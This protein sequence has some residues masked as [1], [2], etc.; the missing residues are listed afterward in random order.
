MDED[1]TLSQNTALQPSTLFGGVSKDQIMAMTI[2]ESCNQTWKPL[3][4][5]D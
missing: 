3:F 5:R 1:S 4:N 2:M